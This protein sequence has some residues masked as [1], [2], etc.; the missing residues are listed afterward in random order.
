MVE[1]ESNAITG[2]TE[3]SALLNPEMAVAQQL[4]RNQKSLENKVK[5]LKELRLCVGTST[6]QSCNRSDKACTKCEFG[7]GHQTV[8]LLSAQELFELF[9]KSILYLTD[10]EKVIKMLSDFR[11]HASL[12]NFEKDELSAQIKR[13]SAIVKD[14]F[15]DGSIISCNLY[16]KYR[17]DSAAEAVEQ[18]QL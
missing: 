12:S 15:S 2:R 13:M 11:E 10:L 14:M 6:I 16:F 3:L 17:V 7:K 4:S 18:Q 5:K 9:G 1:Q 8:K